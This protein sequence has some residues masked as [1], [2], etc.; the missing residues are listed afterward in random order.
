MHPERT[1]ACFD[2][3]SRTKHDGQLFRFVS[4]EDVGLF[5]SSKLLRHEARITHI[6]GV[7]DSTND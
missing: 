3:A 7:K 4:F 1:A 6:L 2:R 5:A